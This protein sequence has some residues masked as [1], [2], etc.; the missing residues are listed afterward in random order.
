L[1]KRFITCG[2]LTCGEEC[3]ITEH[4]EAKAGEGGKVLVVMTLQEVMRFGYDS[5]D[6]A[7]RGTRNGPSSN[8]Q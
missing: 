2:C 5:W 8:Q 6:P 4:G 1:D 7:L 3:E